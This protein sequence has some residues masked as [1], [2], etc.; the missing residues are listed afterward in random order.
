MARSSVASVKGF[1]GVVSFAVRVGEWGAAFAFGEIGERAFFV[2]TCGGTFLFC[3]IA[4]E[5]CAP[6]FVENHFSGGAKR[7]IGRLAV[8][9]GGGK[10]TVGGRR[11]R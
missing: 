11:P 3:R 2:R 1:G 6:T 5:H 10:T 7:Y 4:A 8:D 9:S